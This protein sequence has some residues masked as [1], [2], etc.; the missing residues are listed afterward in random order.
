MLGI[1]LILFNE[2]LYL[3]PA[4]VEGDTPPKKKLKQGKYHSNTKVIL[5][6]ATVN[7]KFSRILTNIIN[8]FSS[9][10]IPSVESS[11]TRI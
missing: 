5:S 11:C 8:V 6:V 9:I 1:K 3:F 2:I 7:L 10:T 4:D